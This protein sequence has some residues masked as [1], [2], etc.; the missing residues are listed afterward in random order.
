MRRYQK[1]TRKLPKLKIDAQIFNFETQNVF[2]FQTKRN[3]SNAV[4][5][6]FYIGR[7]R[8]TRTLKN[9]FGDRH[10]TITSYP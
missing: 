6:P 10:V 3:G 7:G 1:Y 5:K 9:G 2:F 8:R 4:F